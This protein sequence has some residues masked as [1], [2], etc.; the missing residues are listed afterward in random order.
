MHKLQ[1]SALKIAMT[2]RKKP[3]AQ[4]A[5]ILVILAFGLVF[6]NSFQAAG[7]PEENSC[8]PVELSFA[9]GGETP[10]AE[11]V[12]NETNATSPGALENASQ[13]N[14]TLESNSSEDGLFTPSIEPTAEP[15]PEPTPETPAVEE[16][17][18]QKNETAPAKEKTQKRFKIRGSRGNEITSTLTLFNS[19][20]G[21]VETVLSG[22]DKAVDAWDNGYDAEA[23]FEDTAVKKIRFK[24]LNVTDNFS[25]GVDDVPL[26]AVPAGALQAYAIDPSALQFEEATATITAQGTEL[27]KCKDWSFE[28]QSCG[29]EW[30]KILDLVPG[31]D[32]ELP[33][34][35]ADPA[36]YETGYYNF[37]A[38]TRCNTTAA[39]AAGGSASN[40]KFCAINLT[41]SSGWDSGT[42]NNI[43]FFANAAASRN[44]GFGN[45]PT[46]SNHSGWFDRDTTP[47]NGNEKLVN[48][49]AYAAGF[50]INNN[51]VWTVAVQATDGFN[52]TNCTTWSSGYCTWN[53]NITVSVTC[54]VG[55]AC[56]ANTTLLNVTYNITL[57]DTTPPKYYS[58]GQNKTTNIVPSD[59]LKFYA[60][61]TDVKNLSGYIFSWNATGSWANDS[62]VAFT[63][64]LTSNWS[65]A[66]KTIPSSADGQAVGWM[67]YA[68]DSSGNWNATPTTAFYVNATNPPKY[69]SVGQNTSAPNP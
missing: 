23:V 51:V 65:N 2:V 24:K 54:G 40:S 37:T 10:G 38:L 64:V 42:I 29:G 34:S 39:G 30:A 32:Y 19:T 60:N 67:I 8:R 27:Y 47:V 36:F 48:Y 63:T 16:N 11:T 53:A 43:T 18:T 46:A 20:T 13:S 6:A 1:S 68:N 21:A 56:T 15:T 12:L 31:Q 44:G 58:V 9:D 22:P 57:Y 41:F 3:T 17:A 33:L 61:W 66:T 59:S 4:F 28:A 45:Q 26:G 25:L 69:Y 55:R 35:A 50:P 49:S 62:A 52:S 7:A 14:E 5:V